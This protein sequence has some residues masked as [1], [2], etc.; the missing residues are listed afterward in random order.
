M[1][2]SGLEVTDF[3]KP[4][5]LG[6]VNVC[7]T[8]SNWVLYQKTPNTA[9]Y[10]CLSTYDRRT[11][12]DVALAESRRF[13]SLL[14]RPS[15]VPNSVRPTVSVVW[16]R[17]RQPSRT[18]VHELDGSF[19]FESIYCRPFCGHVV[20]Y[21]GTTMVPT[22]YADVAADFNRTTLTLVVCH[23]LGS[24]WNHRCKAARLPPHLAQ[25]RH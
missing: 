7:S 8:R 6:H 17:I 1:A 14:A 24:R 12:A 9:R 3:Q 23:K 19:A 11:L 16:S 20:E 2:V 21:L 13:A 4:D 25:T 10:L 22:A 5:V 15:P 18:T